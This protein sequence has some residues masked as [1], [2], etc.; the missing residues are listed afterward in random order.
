[1]LSSNWL[2]EFRFGWSSIKFLMTPIDFG[3]NPAQVVGLGDQ[4]ELRPSA[5]TLG[6]QNIRNLG[7]NSNQPLITNQNDFQIFDS[8]TRSTGGT[9]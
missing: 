4:P 8:V 2:N 5:M 1:M 7:A 3:T 9:P 6:F